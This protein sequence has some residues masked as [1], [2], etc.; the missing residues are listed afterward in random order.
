MHVSRDEETRALEEHMDKDIH[1][2]MGETLAHPTM[3]CVKKAQLDLVVLR[4]MAQRVSV[5]LRSLASGNEHSTTCTLLFRRAP[6]A[7]ASYGH[8]Q[9]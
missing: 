8:L 1:L 3:P 9:S 5:T 4:Y 6:Q 2:N 7:H